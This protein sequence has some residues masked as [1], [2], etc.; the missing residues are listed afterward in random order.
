VAARRSSMFGKAAAGRIVGTPEDDSLQGTDGNDVFDLRGGGYDSASGLAG[1]DVFY[2]GAR[3]GSVEI[4]GGGNADIVILQGDYSDG[5][6]LERIANLGHLGSLS[7][8]S[9]AND[10]Y[11]GGAAAANVYTLIA[12]DRLVAA[13]QVLKVN[14]GGLGPGEP[15]F[16]DGSEE[17]DGAFWIYGGKGYDTLRGGAGDDLFIFGPDGRYE[18]DRVDGGGGH[19][20]IVLR[21]QYDTVFGDGGMTSNV[22]TLR[23]LSSSDASFGGGGGGGPFHYTIELGDSSSRPGSLFTVDARGLQADETLVVDARDETDGPVRIHAGSGANYLFGGG[24]A[25][26]FVFGPGADP[27]AAVIHGGP[28]YD[29][30]YLRG[31]HRV[32]LGFA[33][34]LNGVESV[35]LLSRHDTGFGSG[36][37]DGAFDYHLYLGD[38]VAAPGGSFTV[39]GSRLAADESMTIDGRDVLSGSLRIFGGAG[40]DELIGGA[41]ADLIAGGG[42]GDIL[43]GNGGADLFRFQS[44]GDGFDFIRDFAPGVDRIDLS[45][46]DADPTAAGDQ[47]FAFVGPETSAPPAGTVRVRYHDDIWV[48]EIHLDGD[49]LADLQIYLAPAGAPLTAADFLL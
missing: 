28:G 11:G 15:L 3:A 14:A 49:F 46:I 33:D 47:S 39:N 48:V 25:D 23:L 40:D 4:D 17:T 10:L 13:G 6:Y 35:A 20:T 2:V 19:D 30:L 24:G 22:E 9:S 29:V 32:G 43:T 21:G 8:L 38:G 1:R 45:R 34:M 7:L 44:V 36:G 5:L 26:Q 18:Y 27:G 42:G 41:G 12:S 31:D 37:G 16:F